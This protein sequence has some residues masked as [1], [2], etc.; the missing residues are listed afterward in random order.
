MRKKILGA[1]VIF[2]VTLAILLMIDDIS[3][4]TNSQLR[5]NVQMYDTNEEPELATVDRE[6]D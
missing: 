2:F 5:E 4:T 1:I 3:N 6:E